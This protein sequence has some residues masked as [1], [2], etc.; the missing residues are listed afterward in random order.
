[1]KDHEFLNNAGKT[2]FQPTDTKFENLQ[3]YIIDNSTREPFNPIFKQDQNT[4]SFQ[5]YHDTIL[6]EFIE[7]KDDIY[8]VK[9][10]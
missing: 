9:D 3:Q 1:L 6:M 5:D 10:Q 2:E 7:E 4:M 8:Y